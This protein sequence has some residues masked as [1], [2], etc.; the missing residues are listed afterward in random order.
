MPRMK[1]LAPAQKVVGASLGGALGVI[2][3]KVIQHIFPSFEIDLDLQ[4]AVMTLT[5]FIVG[6]FVPP[7]RID[8]VVLDNEQMIDGA[9]NGTE[10]EV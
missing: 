10:P 6:Y 8:V 4:L 5:A 9:G 7:G 3:L 1:T 2:A